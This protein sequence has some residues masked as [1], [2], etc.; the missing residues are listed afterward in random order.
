MCALG[1]VLAEV[2]WVLVMSRCV[3]KRRGDKRMRRQ[4]DMVIGGL[5]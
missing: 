5:R 4:E 1:L 2:W 3:V